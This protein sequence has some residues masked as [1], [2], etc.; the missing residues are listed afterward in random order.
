MSKLWKINGLN[1]FI[2]LYLFFTRK[3]LETSYSK[4]NFNPSHIV[5]FSTT[6][7]GD[8]L[9]NTPAIKAVRRRFP[10]AKITLI[11]HRK[12]AEILQHGND[13][14]DVL[15]WN[16]KLSTI[17]HIL[18]QLKKEPTID[19]SLLLHSHEPYDYLCAILAGSRLVIRDNYNDNV[20]L[21]DKWLA[22]YMIAFQ[23]HIIE[24]KLKLVE[25]LG[26]DITDIEMKFP[27]KVD[28]KTKTK[29]AVIGFQLGASKPDRCWPPEYFSKAAQQILEYYPDT[30]IILTGG[31]DE[32]NKASEFYLF[33]PEKYHN[34]I[35]NKVASTNLLELASVI[36]KMDVLL[37]GDTGPL[38]VAISLKTP[39]L[40]LF[41]TANPYST[42]AYQDPDLHDFIYIAQRKS[43]LDNKYTMGQ[44]TPEMVVTKIQ[45]KLNKIKNNDKN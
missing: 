17:L 3:K 1:S 32:K 30:T 31:P 13:W 43:S 15:Y 45:E 44:I 40:G 23:G 21:R 34:N 6:A 20:P 16:N 5:V 12:F 2:K 14:D 9:F 33:L 35:I 11:A 7:L 36:N 38:H 26:C 39:T 10:N 19:L 42:G 25:G 8:F 37:T 4:E 22:D 41:V 27:Y 18:R 24:R 28:A 29:H